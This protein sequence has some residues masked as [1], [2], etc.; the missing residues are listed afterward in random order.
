[1]TSRLLL[2]QEKDIAHQKNAKTVEEQEIIELKRARWEVRRLGISGF[3]KDEK[4]EEQTKLLISLG[5]AVCWLL[6]SYG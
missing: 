6:C 2:F 5:A 1:M 3:V 4:E